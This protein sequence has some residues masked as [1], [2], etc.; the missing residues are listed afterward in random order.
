MT[1][2]PLIGFLVPTCDDAATLERCLTSLMAQ[3]Y[4][5]LM[6]VALDNFSK[7]ET[8]DILVA[9]ERRH[10]RRLYVGRT[11][12]RLSPMDHRIR[13]RQMLNPRA[14]LIQFVPP[15]DVLAP[16][17]ASRCQEV[18]AD[19]SRVGFVSVHADA[20]L[21]GGAVRPAP[22]YRPASGV[23]EGEAQFASFMADGLPTQTVEMFR[24]EAYNLSLS[25]KYLFNRM[26]MAL[27][28]IMAASIADQ[29]YLAEPLALRG[30]P[31]AVLG[32]AF[33]PDLSDPFEHYLFLQ[34]FQTIAARLGRQGVADLLPRAIVRLAA[35]CLR[36]GATL[37]AAGDATRA[38]AF[39]S[40]A[41]AYAPE[42]AG[43][44]AFKLAAGSC[45][46][47]PLDWR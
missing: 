18:F 26:P 9:F 25:E 5:D 40:L 12:A 8:Y 2:P 6:V 20:I 17:Y 46:D 13:L 45:P 28:A 4:G 27:A 37:A 23:L 22:K 47:Q 42:L 41:L 21:P 44:Q 14:R 29:G 11:Y 1:V 38:R 24:I 39:L 19:H 10:R 7:D 33:V 3:D 36:C 15:T 34:A 43:T 35:D 31:Q 30:D 32:D 16:A